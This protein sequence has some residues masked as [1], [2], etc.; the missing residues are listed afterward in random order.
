M[1]IKSP[2]KVT[3]TPFSW[4]FFFI[5]W[6][7]SMLCFCQ[8]VFVVVVDCLHQFSLSKYLTFDKIV[9]N[10]IDKITFTE[11]IVINWFV[12][13]YTTKTNLH[14][15]KFQTFKGVPLFLQGSN[16]K[17]DGNQTIIQKKYRR[18]HF[19]VSKYLHK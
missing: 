14:M 10:A 18:K 1:S 8:C 5:C 2:K 3:T 19:T 16:L 12:F 7:I 13:L 17:S 9:K 6:V 15:L 11:P 4:H